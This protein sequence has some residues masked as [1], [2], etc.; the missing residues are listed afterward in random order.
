MIRNRNIHEST[1]LSLLRWFYAQREW[2]FSQIARYDLWKNL[3][4]GLNGSF[5]IVQRDESAIQNSQQSLQFI[6]IVLK[7]QDVEDTFIVQYLI[8]NQHRLQALWKR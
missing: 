3:S 5:L 2:K 8:G 6:D 7:V 4:S 1:E